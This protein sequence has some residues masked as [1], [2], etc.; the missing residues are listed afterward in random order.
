VTVTDDDGDDSAPKAIDVLIDKTPPVI[1]VFEPRAGYYHNTD[2]IRVVVAVEDPESGGVSSG[3]VAASVVVILDGQE[4]KAGDLLDLSKLADG[5][6]TLYVA[7]SDYAGSSA[8]QEVIFEVGPVPALVHIQPHKWDL[9]WLDPFDNLDDHK[10]QKAVK[11]Q[12]SL[13]TA[14]VETIIPT[15]KAAKLE[16]G[17]RYGDFLVVDV[18]AARTGAKPSNQKVASVTL[19]YVGVDEI[20]ILAFSGDVVRDFYSVNAGDTIAIDGGQ[21]GHLARHTVLSVYT[22]DPPP[23]SAADILPETVFLN[24]QAL[25]IE[26]SARLITKDASALE[27]SRVIAEP[28]FTIAKEKKHHVWL[29]NLDQPQEITLAVGSQTIFE[30]EPYPI[31]WQ[32]W[33]SL[34]DDGQLQM[35]RIHMSGKDNLLQVLHHNLQAEA[36]IYLDGALALTILPETKLVVMEVLFNAFDVISTLDRQDIQ[37]GGDWLVTTANGATLKGK[38]PR[39]H[40]TVSDIGNPQKVKLVIGDTVIF[41][42]LPFP[43]KWSDRHFLV[44]G[45]RQDMSIRTA[46]HKHKSPE[47]SIH[48][49][50]LTQEAKLYLDDELVLLISPPPEVAVSI[51]GELELDGDPA[52]YDGSFQGSDEIELKGKLPK[53]FEPAKIYRQLNTSGDPALE[54][55]DRIGEFEVVHFTQRYHDYRVTDLELSYDGLNATEISIYEDPG[56]KHL[57]DSYQA[58]PGD[59]F[60]MDVSHL[61]GNR[62]VLEIG[63]KHVAIDLSGKKAAVIGDIF[64]DCTVFETAKAPLGPPHYIDLTLEYVG[65]KD[66]ISLTVY[67]GKK[68]DVIAIYEVEPAA[69]TVFTID[70]SQLPKGYLGETLVLEYGSAEPSE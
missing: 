40:I 27:Q 20:D 26:G 67:D 36:R 28:P 57:I 68:K 69:N 1:E 8:E 64:L 24:G 56:R 19:K 39:K 23:L 41:D 52:T 42:D 25:I 3:L 4:I 49:K 18:V 12:I 15:D 44:D 54:I 9:K 2:E 35:M 66:P 13:E 29:A 31:N 43:I 21:A 11:A 58:F 48:C 55:G 37:R 50:K 30:D 7:A 61:D 51:T 46:G 16:A 6:H 45:Q 53:D 14:E 38:H 63:K 34:T 59:Y 60:L 5:F 22:S 17:T 70:G 62:V 32:D 33:F 47:L 65:V 10:S